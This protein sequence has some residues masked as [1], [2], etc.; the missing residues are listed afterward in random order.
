VIDKKT[1]EVTTVLEDKKNHTIDSARYALENVR[2]A[3]NTTREEL[4]I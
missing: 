1:G 4:R 2:R 3:V